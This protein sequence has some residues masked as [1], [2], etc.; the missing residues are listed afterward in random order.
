MLR[1]FGLAVSSVCLGAGCSLSTMGLKPQGP[2]ATGA[3]GNVE[4]PDVFKMQKDAALAALKQ[5]GFTREVSYDTSLCGSAVNGQIV[6]LGEVCYQQPAA[7][8]VMGTS[9]PITL[10]VQTED[11]RH[12]KVGA[13]GEWHLMP[14]L[15]GMTLSDAQRAMHDAGFTDDM[16]QVGTIE[17]PGCA[18]LRV[19]RTFPD[20]LARAGQTSGRVIYVG[21]DPNAKPTREADPVTDA[22]ANKPTDAAK[23]PDDESSDKPF[24]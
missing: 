13:F 18:P 11:P 8:Q 24:F 4:I 2:G 9:L 21:L 1:R 20:A 7:G 10:R 16:T 5:R 6:E 12:G 14:K 23:K 3:S 17:E 19:C 22:A 15:A